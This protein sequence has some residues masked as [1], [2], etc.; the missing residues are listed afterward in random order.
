MAFLKFQKIKQASGR[1][2]V[3]ISIVQAERIPLI[4]K[5]RQ[6]YLATVG[7]YCKD[8]ASTVYGR[9]AIIGA[10]NR[11]CIRA[12]LSRKQIDEV[13]RSMKKRFSGH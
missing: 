8:I 9:L 10:V 13:E 4:N 6:H 7:T 3:C 5:T 12:R 1:T 2:V 11:A